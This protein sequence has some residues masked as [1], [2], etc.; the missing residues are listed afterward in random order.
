MQFLNT[1]FIEKSSW[2]I[3]LDGERP[4]ESEY[5]NEHMF[6]LRRSGPAYLHKYGVQ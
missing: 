1:T 6:V 4:W 5:D 3:W 2:K